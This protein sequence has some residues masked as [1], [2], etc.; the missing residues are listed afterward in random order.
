MGTG[1]E[2]QDMAELYSDELV[3]V[4]FSAV[5][6]PREGW[7]LSVRRMWTWSKPGAPEV[8]VY[9]RLTRGELLDVLD[10]IREQCSTGTEF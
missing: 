9:S 5:H 7:N 1:R 3:S 10:V 2:G 6:V 4:Q 8:E